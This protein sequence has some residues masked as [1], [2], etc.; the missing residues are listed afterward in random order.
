MD[1]NS[2]NWGSIMISERCLIVMR[3]DCRLDG[4]QQ[5]LL[6]TLPIII[7]LITY[8]HILTNRKPGVESMPES[9]MRKE[10]CRG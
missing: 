2:K 4:N 6:L 7:L 8:Y 3:V 5:G 9:K 1:T 10:T